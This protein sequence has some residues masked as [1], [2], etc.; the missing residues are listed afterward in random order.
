MK[1]L[2][3]CTLLV[4]FNAFG[5]TA[6]FTGMSQP[7]QTVTYQQGWRCQYNYAGRT[8]WMVFTGF[9]PATVEVQ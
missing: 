4:S 3:L 1:A 7:I 8:F 9:C 5:A 2:I 6:F